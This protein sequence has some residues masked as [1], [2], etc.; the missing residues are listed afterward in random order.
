MKGQCRQQALSQQALIVGKSRCFH[1]AADGCTF[2][3]APVKWT[4]FPYYCPRQDIG[5]DAAVK[6]SDSR[7]DSD[8]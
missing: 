5:D 4:A 2:C 6:G 7:S 8:S 1:H 3:H